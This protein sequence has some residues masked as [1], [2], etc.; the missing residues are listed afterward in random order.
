MTLWNEKPAKKTTLRVAAC[1]RVSTTSDE[2]YGSL[3]IR[4]RFELSRY[5]G[6][7]LVNLLFC[8]MVIMPAYYVFCSIAV[9][10]TDDIIMCM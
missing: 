4:R 2:Q 7:T 6:L 5:G 1:C 8:D 10:I 3:K 9:F